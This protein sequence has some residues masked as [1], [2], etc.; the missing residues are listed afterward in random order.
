MTLAPSNEA[1]ELRALERERTAALV[2]ADMEVAQRLHA[3]DFQ[4]INPM[5]GAL[6]KPEYLGLIASGDLR[7]LEWAPEDVQ[8][9]LF[10]DAAVIRYRA[11]LRIVVKGM[12]N[13]PSGRFWFMDLYEKR[14]GRWQVVWSQATLI[15]PGPGPAR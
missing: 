9:R 14:D 2:R 12:P 4:L 6:S 13:A 15:Q 1:D 10:G 7:Y 8:V 11:P 3:D 5:G